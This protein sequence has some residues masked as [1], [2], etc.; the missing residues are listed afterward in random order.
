MGE[1]YKRNYRDQRHEMGER[2]AAPGRWKK[3]LRALR[4]KM[5]VQCQRRERNVRGERREELVT[6]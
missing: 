6:S 4:G 5:N 1:K 3:G 2:S